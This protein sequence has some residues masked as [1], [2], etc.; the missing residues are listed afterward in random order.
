MDLLVNIK[1]MA[2]KEADE[3]PIDVVIDMDKKGAEDLGTNDPDG[4]GDKL[5]KDLWVLFERAEADM[6][7]MSASKSNVDMVKVMWKV[8]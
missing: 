5:D 4:Y 1:A 8:S 3:A 2:Q 7:D 6:V